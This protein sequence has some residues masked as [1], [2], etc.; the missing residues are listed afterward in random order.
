MPYATNKGVRIFYEVSGEGRPFILLHANPCSNRM[1]MYQIS[2]FS[3][4]FRVIS[5]DMRAYGRSDKPTEPCSFNDLVEDILAVCRAENVKFGVVA[6]A[7]MGSKI[8]MKLSIENPKLFDANVLIG[9]NAFKGN[10]YDNRIKGYELA[11]RK[12]RMYRERHLNELFTKS[13][14]KTDL[15][16]Y[17]T[18]MILS[19]SENLS[20]F[21]ISQLFRSFDG[22]DLASSLSTLEK[23]TL[24]I[25]GEFDSALEGAQ[26]T[27]SLIP[28]TNHV[29]IKD[30]GHLCNLEKP[31]WVDAS[32]IK[33]L[34]KNNML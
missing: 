20:G 28:K 2:T 7:S 30:A 14:T 26:S 3:Q 1:W 10:S 11:G 29:I 8:A 6:G 21:A 9:G 23:P 32:I 27:L 33:F 25:N 18:S 4:W 24:I 5:P 12:V 22:V 19:D 13:F 15:G 17:L 34:I 31:D 16:K